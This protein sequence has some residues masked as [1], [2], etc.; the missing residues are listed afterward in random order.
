MQVFSQRNLKEAVTFSVQTI[1]RYTD[2]SPDESNV[3]CS[4]S[5]C[6]NLPTD[7][8]PRTRSVQRVPSPRKGNASV[9]RR[10][11]EAHRLGSHA[12]R[13]AWTAALRP[14]STPFTSPR[15]FI[16][17]HRKSRGDPRSCTRLQSGQAIVREGDQRPGIHIYN[18]Y[19]PEFM[20]VYCFACTTMCQVKIVYFSKPCYHNWWR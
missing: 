8:T 3:N 6:P 11:V 7:A 17:R 9:F 4:T 10:T 13:R 19:T 18:I 20:Y 16:A 1:W 15:S 14:R 12:A 2:S 5:P